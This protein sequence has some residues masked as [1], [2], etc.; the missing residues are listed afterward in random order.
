[1]SQIDTAPRKRLMRLLYFVDEEV[2][3]W[4]LLDRFPALVDKKLLSHI[5]RSID[6]YKK[7]VPNFRFQCMKGLLD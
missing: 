7:L 4:R 6:I 1:M 3:I 5:E 2:I